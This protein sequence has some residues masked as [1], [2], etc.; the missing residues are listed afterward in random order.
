MKRIGN[1][2]TEDNITVEL[3]MQ[4]IY[5]ASKNKK[6][7]RSVLNVLDNIE[8]YSEILRDMI[9]NE[10]FKPSPYSYEEREENGK[11]RKLLKPRFFPDQCIHHILIMLIRDK[12]IK[13]ID[14]HAVASIPNRGQAM[15]F[16]LIEKWLKHDKECNT[17]YAI[18][19]DIQKFFENV[20]PNVIMSVYERMIKDKK[21]LRLKSIVTYS[22]ESM[23]LGNYCSAYDANLLLKDM[24]EFIR[25][26]VFVKHYVRYMDDFIIFCT[27]KR[28]ARLL[29]SKIA[30]I[31]K[32]SGLK[33]KHTYQLFRL[34][35][36]GLDFIG[37]RFYRDKVILR[38][39]N[40]LKLI[41]QVKHI[42][43]L[44]TIPVY[45]CQS[46]MSRLGMAKHCYSKS[47]FKLIHNNLDVYKLKA[48]IAEN[49]RY[50]CIGINY[51]PKMI[52]I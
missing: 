47:L 37:Y 38:K 1:L 29:Y 51:I 15:A 50:S 5:E 7:R 13:R 48:I 17:R 35:D 36:R 23:P 18:K 3:C 39:R 24:D 9:L 40:Y 32:V 12:I 6:K 22:C 52:L 27:N 2:I 33:L 49:S 42:L 14:P 30:D 4:A 45:D 16:K 41:K 46:L 43:K 26:N 25:S 20:K 31:I 19:G 28:K 44:F 8:E 34:D 10:T 11:I 21:Y